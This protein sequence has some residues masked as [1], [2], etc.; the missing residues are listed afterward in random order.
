MITAEHLPGVLIITADR[1]SCHFEDKSEWLLCRKIFKQLS[2]HWGQ[3]DKDI[4]ALRVFDQVPV[5]MAWKPDL[6]SK[7]KNVL[8]QKWSH[9]YPYTFTLFYLPDKVLNR[10]RQ[11]KVTM[12]LITLFCENTTMVHPSSRNVC[13]ESY[14]ITKHPK[15]F[16]S[17]S[18]KPS[19]TGGNQLLTT[20]GLEDLT[21]NLSLLGVLEKATEL[22][23][24]VRRK[25]KVS[26]YEWDWRKW[27]GWFSQQQIDPHKCLVTNV[28]DFSAYLA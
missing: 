28:L 10:V 22:I 12:V 24:C 16:G 20:T 23:T 19:S 27:V 9:L 6:H 1:V 26:N 5:Y 13:R 4:F 15:A 21:K 18:E 17:S 8:Q 3:P 7:A 11:E 25:G 2:L 14:T